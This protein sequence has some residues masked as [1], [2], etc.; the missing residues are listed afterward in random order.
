MAS[1]HVTSTCPPSE[2]VS[3]E[4][5]AYVRRCLVV[6]RELLLDLPHDALLFVRPR[7]RPSRLLL[8]LLLLVLV[9][10]RELLLDLLLDALL[11]PLTPAL[12]VVLRGLSGIVSAID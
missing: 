8:G 3:T 12:P 6:A 10:A 1:A 11:L 7:P 5:R 4:A 9:A 2:T